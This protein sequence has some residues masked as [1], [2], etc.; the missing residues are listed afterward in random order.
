MKRCCETQNQKLCK[1]KKKKNYNGK[2]TYFKFQTVR[3]QLTTM[4]TEEYPCSTSYKENQADASQQDEMLRLV[5]GWQVKVSQ[6]LNDL[7]HGVTTNF[8]NSPNSANNFL[9]NTWQQFIKVNY[10]FDPETIHSKS[11]KLMPRA[12]QRLR[13]PHD[14]LSWWHTHEPH[15]QR[16][17]VLTSE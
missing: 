4:L 1:I 15:G 9:L 6:D 12:G 16:C 10:M 2:D 11:S 5:E 14:F 3:P 13:G 8:H 7:N 17:H